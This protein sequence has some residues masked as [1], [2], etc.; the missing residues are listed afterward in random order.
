MD[1][2]RTLTVG[3]GQWVVVGTARTGNLIPLVLS[4]PTPFRGTRDT[5][6]NP[7]REDD[8]AWSDPAAGGPSDSVVGSTATAR[9]QR[10]R[11]AALAQDWERAGGWVWAGGLA[12]R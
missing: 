2:P 9:A 1:A 7:G 8:R 5:G 3:T 4:T 10:H 11:I 12:S 6:P